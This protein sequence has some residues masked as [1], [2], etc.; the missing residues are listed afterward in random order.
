M[1]KTR[2]FLSYL[3]LI[4]IINQVCAQDLHNKPE[5]LP[6]TSE[7]LIKARFEKWKMNLLTDDDKTK[8]V[9]QQILD[10]IYVIDEYIS[11]DWDA[12][13]SM[14]VNSYK[15]DP[16]YN[17]QDQLIENLNLNWNGS[18][19]E[20][21]YRY[22]YTYTG[23]GLEAT[24]TYQTWGGADWVNVSRSSITYDANNRAV[25]YLYE[26][27]I[28]ASWENSTR[29]VET[30][31]SNGN[32][33]TEI[34]QTWNGT[35]WD[36]YYKYS[37]TYNSSNFVT[38]YLSQ[39]WSGGVWVNNSFS[40]RSYT[41]SGELS[42]YI[43]Y[44]WSGTAWTNSYQYMY[45][46]DS[47]GNETNLLGQKWDPANGWV[48][49]SQST[50]QYDSNNNNTESLSQNWDTGTSGWVNYSK[51]IRTYNSA[52]SI[53]TATSQIWNTGTGWENSA[54]GS[55]SY[56]AN[57]NY[58]EISYKNWDTGSS[59]WVN[60]NRYTAFL[61][62]MITDVE[63]DGMQINTFK[64]YD[65]YPN[66]FNPSTKIRFNV[67]S[68]SNVTIRVYDI[69]GKEIKSLVNQTL[70][71]GAHEIEFNGNEIASGVYL[72][73]V[74]AHSIDKKESFVATK[75]MILLK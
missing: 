16:M 12:G 32:L 8:I 10:N 42:T 73:K 68:T 50:Y 24:Y 38:E 4:M 14:W 74:E 64:L 69:T 26:N 37:Y 43:T 27:W 46:Y 70:E 44:T 2:L 72:Y 75:K 52:N 40:T 9:H 18:S 29:Y 5:K 33:E 6:V 41:L 47:N 11:Q 60:S 56:D 34:Y 59:S 66:P 17:A 15:Y 54:F 1:K 49:Y 35:S 3:F 55:Y 30:Y 7:D 65:N 45:T 57:N 22:V 19:W 67:P 51:N 36:N 21:Y 63:D 23:N 31:L 58:S 62:I 71:H 39:I 48:N 25:E 20:N 13:S 61:W 28:G 53:L